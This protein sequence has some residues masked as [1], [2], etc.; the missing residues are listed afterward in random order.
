MTPTRALLAL[1]ALAPAAACA[2]NPAPIDGRAVA[3]QADRHQITLLEGEE[4]LE[5]DLFA[6]GLSQ[7]QIEE[8]NA[9]GRMYRSIGR[10]PLQIEAPAEADPVFVAQVRGALVDGG[11]NFA[12]LAQTSRPGVNGRV[13]L[14]FARVE[15]RAPACAPIHTQ[16]LAA[17][18]NNRSYESFGCAMAANLA[19]MIADPADLEKPRA[20]GPRDGARR[21]TV[22]GKY[23]NGEPT[24]ATRSDDE[25]VGVSDVDGSGN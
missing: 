17:Q 3:T 12:A 18:S 6:E 1:L 9:F 5:L 24:H 25:R 21:T 15:A 22:F 23:R 19:A 11:V 14:R 7:A 2:G 20:F 16:D 4:Q 13:A 10:G 8:L